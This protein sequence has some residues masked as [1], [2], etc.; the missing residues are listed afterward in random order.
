MV[1]RVLFIP[2]RTRHKTLIINYPGGGGSTSTKTMKKLFT[3]AFLSL[4]L[5]SLTSF[6][7]VK[8]QEMETYRRSSLNMIMLE[9]PRIDPS[10][11][12]QVRQSFIANPIPDKY[13]DHSLASVSKTVNMDDII[14]TPADYEES[15]AVL[16]TKKKKDNAEGTKKGAGLVSLLGEAAG[17]K[18]GPTNPAYHI[19]N[20]NIDTTKRWIPHVAYKYLKENNVAK[21][22]VD[23]W[24]NVDSGKMSIDLVKERAYYN[25]TEAE[26]N[27]AAMESDRNPI[28][29]IMDNGG[30]EI[31][32]NSFV[33][34]SRFRYVNAEQM[35]AE[36]LEKAAIGAAFLPDAVADAEMAIAETAASAAMLSMG[37]G[38][39]VY[40]N[41]YLFRLVW[42]DE[43]FEMINSC[44]NDLNA[45]NA[46]DC[47]KLE[48]VGEESAY[49]NITA[50]K[51]TPDEAIQ[52]AMT[53]AM[54]K[55]LA[56]LEKEY[57]VFRTKTPLTNID[58]LTANI[59]TKECVEKGDKYEI[60]IKELKEVKEGKGQ[61]KTVIEYKRAGVITVDQVGNNM[62]EDNDDENASAQTYTTFKG[63][64]PK[65]VQPG[66]LIRFCK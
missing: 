58:P 64:A 52:F 57:E 4:T 8:G 63:K 3:A 55:V 10:I 14:V 30:H 7:Q 19:D 25:A 27:E 17:L 34:V 51:R 50:G 23:K 42:N 66:T 32:G 35:A 28:D 13:N 37:D 33:T 40:T 20:L 45:Y 62:G 36:I 41:T 46:L 9:D 21:K 65:N 31:I 49:A 56:K 24:F 59:G 15:K 26:I 22:M 6:A 48:Y 16:N 60:L 61:K 38:Y 12:N 2:P 54:D 1:K 39:A 18:M 47:F 44:A 29:V 11:I 43:T 5:A 53:R